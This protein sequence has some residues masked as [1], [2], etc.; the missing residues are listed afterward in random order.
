MLSVLTLSQ[1]HDSYKAEIL[2]W[3]TLS[4]DVMQENKQYLTD[5][6]IH[7][8][9]TPITASTW[10]AVSKGIGRLPTVPRDKD[11]G[12]ILKTTG[13]A[14]ISSVGVPVGLFMARSSCVQPPVMSKVLT[15]DDLVAML[16]MGLEG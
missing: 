10:H 16:D 7:P 5:L 6:P 1:N 2:K 15:D 12:N 8:S 13:M 3:I 14:L 11:I 9:A 4:A